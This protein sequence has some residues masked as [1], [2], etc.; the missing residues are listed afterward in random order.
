MLR[1]KSHDK[2]KVLDGF[3]NTYSFGEL[4][5]NDQKQH[6]EVYR[7]NQ[8]KAGPE[9]ANLLKREFQR[10]TRFGRRCNLLHDTDVCELFSYII[11]CV[12]NKCD[13]SLALVLPQP[14]PYQT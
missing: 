13:I 5:A 3:L 4:V 9:Q 7:E 1:G 6:F 12:R 11:A 10:L 2:A 8:T 14:L